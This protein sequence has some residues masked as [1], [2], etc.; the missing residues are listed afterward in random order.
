MKAHQEN[1]ELPSLIPVPVGVQFLYF[2]SFPSEIFYNN[3][4]SNS[5]IE[6]GQTALWL[7]QLLVLSNG[8]SLVPSAH[9]G[10]VTTTCNLNFNGSNAVFWPHGNLYIQTHRYT[11]RKTCTQPSDILINL[12]NVAPIDYKQTIY[13][14]TKLQLDYTGLFLPF[15]LWATAIEVIWKAIVATYWTLRLIAWYKN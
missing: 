6:A 7:R 12:Y 8:P 2:V 10:Q 11:K 4:L 1:V 15:H 9:V 3:K 5:N 14:K 13:S